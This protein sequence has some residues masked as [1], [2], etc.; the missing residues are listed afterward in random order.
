MRVF[1]L[2]VAL[3]A[4]LTNA[5]FYYPDVQT[6]LL[7]HILVDNW[8]AYASN[9]SSAITP[10][11]NYVTQ[12]GEAARNSGRTTAAQWM[13]V[14]FHDFITANVSAGTGGVDASIGFE[15]ARGENS[16]SAFND[17]FTFWRPFVNEFVPMADL[18]ALGTVMSNNLCGG[19]IMPYRPGRK[20]ANAADPTT[21]VPA[22]ETDLEETLVFFERAGFD[23]T[24]SIKLTA[25]GHTLG[26]VH[27]GG[28][29]DVVDDSAVTPNNTNGGVNFDTTR[30]V[31]DT[32]VVEEYLAWTGQKGGPLVTTA[33]ITAQSDLRLYE[34]DKN[35]TMRDLLGQGESFKDT[36]VDLLGRAMNTVPGSVELKA[37]IAP[38]TVK[39]INVTFDFGSDGRLFLSGRIRILSGA[40]DSN[41]KSLD[42]HILNRDIKL[43]AESE[44]GRSAWGSNLIGTSTTY[45]TTTYFPFSIDDPSIGKAK[46]FSIAGQ[47]FSLQ[48]ES[49][50]VPSTS[51]LSGTTLNI[52]VAIQQS[53]P[54]NDFTL[55]TASPEVRQG[56]LA[57]RIVE[58]TA[59]FQKAPGLS[60]YQL[61]QSVAQLDQ[62]STGL[63][64]V[65]LLESGVLVDTLLVNGGKAGW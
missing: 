15:T 12:I 7:E 50:I 34:S 29:P 55:E 53:R 56:T 46:S 42:L 43:E 60:G 13:R 24:D 38:L 63:V 45:G 48:G 10:C 14:L 5:A 1:S 23:Q 64:S 37:P 21:G 36:C 28:F 40:N 58:G 57:P 59:A 26:S 44:N 51:T 16:G 11:T 25:C 49:F 41:P 4:G 8:G 6:S 54:C 61:C 3:F 62:E 20:D 47:T 30:G 52:I 17:S 19:H 32:K 35:V 18:V 2:T 9:F 39:P 27:H 33:N 65:K 22:P 31:F